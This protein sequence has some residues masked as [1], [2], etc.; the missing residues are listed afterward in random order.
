VIRGL[1]VDF[2][3][4]LVHEDDLPVARITSLLHAHAASG[5]SREAIGRF[6]YEAFFAWCAGAHD[7]GFVT[8]QM[9]AISTLARTFEAFGIEL[10]PREVI[11]PQLDHWH[12]P[13][14]FPDTPRFP[15]AAESLGLPV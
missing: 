2:Y 9:L 10:D 15:R 3:G 6:W 5:T 4:T 13:P 1:F 12:E 7:A 11:A 8:Q 14:M